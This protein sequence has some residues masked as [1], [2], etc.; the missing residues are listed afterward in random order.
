MGLLKHGF[1]Q[2]EEYYQRTKELQYSLDILTSPEH[3]PDETLFYIFTLLSY[4]DFFA[5]PCVSKKWKRVFD[6]EGMWQSH[7]L[8]VFGNSTLGKISW[9]K[10]FVESAKLI[11]RV[12]VEA[13]IVPNKF[14]D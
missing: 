10:M 3:L 12:L 9:K 4:A 7:C 8:K 11:K 5:I 2:Y 6:N 14:I 1:I 13:V